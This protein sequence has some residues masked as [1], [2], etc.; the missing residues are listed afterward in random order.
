MSEENEIKTQPVTQFF[1]AQGDALT[2]D[3]V[4]DEVLEAVKEGKETTVEVKVEQNETLVEK[5]EVEIQST[6]I[7]PDVPAITEQTEDEIKSKKDKDQANALIANRNAGMV[8]RLRLRDAAGKNKTCAVCM[9]RVP[10]D[11]IKGGH[12]NICDTCNK[13]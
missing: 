4:E 1:S 12:A 2:P 3:Q 5:A 7:T 13:D 8:R 6:R 10:L 9:T 11:Q